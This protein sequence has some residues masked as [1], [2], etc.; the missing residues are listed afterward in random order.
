MTMKG[1]KRGQQ[2]EAYTENWLG[3][4][5]NAP[6]GSNVVRAATTNIV[7]ASGKPTLAG[8]KLVVS[9]IIFDPASPLLDDADKAQLDRIVWSLANKGGLVLIS[10]FA[11]QNKVD[12]KRFLDNLSVERA[13]AVA[14][15]LSG[16]GVRA[17]I[18]YEGYGAVT[19]GI[20][21][22]EDR[23]VEIRWVSGA[24]TLPNE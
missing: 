10:G 2:V 12:T 18:R 17:W 3:V 13:K 4:S 9:R 20:G 1:M 11:R 5:T 7:S 8:G 16:R 21:T 6:W 22:W 23:K 14:N 19:R 15:Y 24:T